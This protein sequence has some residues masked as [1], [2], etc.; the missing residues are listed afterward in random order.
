MLPEVRAAKGARLPDVVSAVT[1]LAAVTLLILA[2]VQGPDWGWTDPRT[3]GL[4]AAALI[5]TV[6]TV[7]RTLRY[8]H[9]LIE[10][11]L[12][13]NR[14]FTFATV[15][16][17]LY[18]VAFAILLLSSVLFLQGVW[19]YGPLKAGLAITPGPATAA[20]LAVNAGR[21]STRFGRTVPAVVGACSRWSSRPSG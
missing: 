14:D 8:P 9:A 15:A 11:T 17:F 1:L 19:H 2:T 5:A 7:T 12:F 13:L 21:I 10:K 20:V 18:Y 6:A 4:F 16:M 3:L